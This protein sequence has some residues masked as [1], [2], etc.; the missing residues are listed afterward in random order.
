MTRKFVYILLIRMA[1]SIVGA[2]VIS[3]FFFD[4]INYVKTPLL[5]GGLLIL[6][7]M[8]ESSRKKE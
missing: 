1:L 7:Y 3:V 4:G 5:A 6:A 8:F 2:S